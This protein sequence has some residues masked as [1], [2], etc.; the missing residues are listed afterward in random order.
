MLSGVC[1]G[2]NDL[3]AAIA[4]YDAVI[5]IVGL[6]RTVREDV[7]AGYGQVGQAPVFA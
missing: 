4:F 5:S 1:L 3:D 7:E 2:T 6:T